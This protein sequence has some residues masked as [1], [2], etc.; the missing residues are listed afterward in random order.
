MLEDVAMKL[1]YIEGMEI[2]LQPAKPTKENVAYTRYADRTEDP[3]VRNLYQFPRG[4][5][6]RIVNNGEL[7]RIQK[8]SVGEDRWASIKRSK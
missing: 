5:P 7:F 3:S 1:T 4:Q 2:F 6:Y 8:W